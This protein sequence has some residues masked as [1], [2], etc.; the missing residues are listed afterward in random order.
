MIELRVDRRGFSLRI[1]QSFHELIMS[2]LFLRIR[3]IGF[4]ERRDCHAVSEWIRVCHCGEVSI[5]G[6]NV[7]DHLLII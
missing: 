1:P 4:G 3:V 5:D 2:L 7:G 6:T